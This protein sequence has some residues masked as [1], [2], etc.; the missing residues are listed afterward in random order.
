MLS[1]IQIKHQI[2]CRLVQRFWQLLNTWMDVLIGNEGTDHEECHQQQE[3]KQFYC[4]NSPNTWITRSVNFV[5]LL[6]VSTTSSRRRSRRGS[7]V[8]T[9]MFGT[10][11]TLI[12]CRTTTATNESNQRYN[13]SNAYQNN[14]WYNE[15][16][17]MSYQLMNK[18]TTEFNIVLETYDMQRPTRPL[19][20]SSIGMGSSNTSSLMISSGS[21][22]ICR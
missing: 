10:S 22:G 5:A 13:Y 17:K 20:L 18:K 4:T 11:F 9:G 14:W 15:S 8:T 2:V 21:P 3:N 6:L 16:P 12:A 19:L 1:I 7:G